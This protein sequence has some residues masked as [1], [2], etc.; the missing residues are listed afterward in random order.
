MKTREH[1]DQLP[2]KNLKLKNKFYPELGQI[3][4]S[5]NSYE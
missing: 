5:N 1:K 3:D 2:I 4:Y